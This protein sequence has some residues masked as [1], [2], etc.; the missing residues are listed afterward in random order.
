MLVL[1]F[2]SSPLGRRLL[3]LLLVLA[4]TT[5]HARPWGKL[6]HAPDVL[7][8][9]PELH[10][11]A[12]LQALAVDLPFPSGATSSNASIKPVLEALTRCT[13]E[14]RN[15]PCRGIPILTRKSIHKLGPDPSFRLLAV[16]PSVL[17]LRR[18]YRRK[19][20]KTPTPAAEEEQEEEE[21]EQEEEEAASTDASDN[22]T[23]EQQSPPA[24]E[25]A[26]VYID[27]DSEEYLRQLLLEKPD[28]LPGPFMCFFISGG[29]DD[30]F[31]QQLEE[32]LQVVAPAFP[33]VT[34]LKG[35]GRDFA[36]LVSQAALKGLP[37]LLLFEDSLLRARFK[38]RPRSV[39]ALLR[40]F[41]DA[42]GSLPA[43][44]VVGAHD[45]RRVFALR[46]A[47]PHVGPLYW[48]SLVFVLMELGLWAFGKKGSGREKEERSQGEAGHGGGG[49]EEGKA[50]EADEEKEEAVQQAGDVPPPANG[51]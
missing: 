37:T 6:L 23:T 25:E 42:T 20:R 24:K 9:V 22:R 49:A 4:T 17:Q 7:L 32:I 1:P 28:G 30:V 47:P 12:W 48:V 51:L 40:F 11:A 31:S 16:D 27:E 18:V 50:A 10:Q 35:N 33:R 38:G 45:A 41:V 8:T 2:A 39:D 43:S 14:K 5:V 13:Y 29:D 19:I 34:F 36:G 26:P 21:E 3:A 44:V 46:P 15:S